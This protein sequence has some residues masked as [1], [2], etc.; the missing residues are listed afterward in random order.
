MYK[1]ILKELNLYDFGKFHN[2]SIKL[3]D[4]FNIIHGNNE[5]GKT[6]I[7]DFIEGIFYGFDDGDKKRKYNYKYEKYKPLNFSNYQGSIL[8]EFKGEKYNIFRD[9]LS[10][11]YEIV[12]LTTKTKVEIVP[13]NLNFPGNYFLDLDYKLYKN[14]IRQNK[15]IFI[16]EKAVT[17]LKDKITNLLN[18]GNSNFNTKNALDTIEKKINRIGSSRAYTKK[19]AITKKEIEE[20][21]NEII[22]LKDLKNTNEKSF[23]E[24]YNLKENIKSLEKERESYIE[25]IKIYNLQKKKKNLKN[26]KS[27]KEK[28]ANINKSIDNINRFDDIDNN[29]FLKVDDLIKRQK[30]LK[31]MLKENKEEVFDVRR[32]LSIFFLAIIVLISI[33]SKNYYVLLLLFI[34]I[35]FLSKPKKENDFVKIR[36]QLLNVE[37]NLQNNFYKIKVKDKTNYERIKVEFLKYESNLKLKEELQ[38]QL[39]FLIENTEF[40]DEDYELMDYNLDIRIDPNIINMKI[41]NIDHNLPNLR[42]KYVKMEKKFSHIENEISVLSNLIEK[43]NDKKALFSKLKDE[44]KALEI[45]YNALIEAQK[46]KNKTGFDKL[47]KKISNMI[48]HITHGDYKD[49]A[50]DDKLGVSLIDKNNRYISIDKLSNGFLSQIYFCLKFVLA[51]SLLNGTFMVFDDAMVE[52]DEIRLRNSLFYLLDTSYESQIIY[53]TCHNREE[54]I[55]KNEDIEIEIIE[56]EDK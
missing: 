27:I 10:E 12:N 32:I 47:E 9:F 44:K 39:D 56:L 38:N 52:F 22:R 1:I 40:N 42:E 7:V 4:D 45:A 36:K 24:I 26:I 41:E 11:E 25:K 55:L 21:D 49:I 51:R 23:E 14:I 2:K 3:R 46:N 54:L 16:E 37:I 20:L 15:E 6:T 17:S 33:F 53:M 43:L 31:E 19:Y 18:N 50:F 28:I 8:I 34:P 30:E 13:S 5:S 29:F 48:K 35:Y